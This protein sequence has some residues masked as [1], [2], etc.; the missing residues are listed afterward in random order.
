[1]ADRLKI[2]IEF[3]KENLEFYANLKKFD[4]AGIIIK[5]VIMGKLPVS[6]LEVQEDV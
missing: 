4:K 3:S 5:N 6:V 1:M 2:T